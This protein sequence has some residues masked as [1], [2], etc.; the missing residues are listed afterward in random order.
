V[1]T[2]SSSAGCIGSL[3]SRIDILVSTQKWS[4]EINIE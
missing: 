2:N 3:P 4:N 1:K